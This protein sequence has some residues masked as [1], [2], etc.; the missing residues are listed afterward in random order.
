MNTPLV[1]VVITVRDGESYIG[2]AIE[3]IISQTLDNWRLIIIDDQ[4]T[5][6]TPRLLS[7][8]L[9]IDN[10]IEVHA[11]EGTGIASA[12]QVGLRNAT[13]K[14]VARFDAD[15]ISFPSRLEKQVRHLE[16]H[17]DLVAL[18]SAVTQ[19]D[20]IGKILSTKKMPCDPASIQALLPHRNC[21][22]HPTSIIR[23]S[24]LENIGGY[25]TQFRLA[26]DYDLW[27]RL[28]KEGRIANLPEPLVYYRK[29]STQVTDR[30]RTA[31]LTLYS[32]AA[33]TDYFLRKYDI[34]LQSCNINE[35]SNDDVA[36]KLTLIY[37]SGPEKNDTKAL[38][39][40]GI[41]LLRH[42]NA[43]G[44]SARLKL[45]GAMRPYMSLTERMKFA[46]YKSL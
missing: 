6:G 39:R 10:R 46:I 18:G 14:Y 19:I 11:G 22:Y 37:N 35:L 8:Y 27:L 44:T 24:A 23:R 21:I 45:Q 1:D 4:S 40:H 30:S 2:Q 3:S 17:K 16:L 13:A 36:E 42:A 32:V 15:D 33:A 26:E 5:D 29:H 38:N 25:R 31:Y 9:Q 20:S 12:A 28:I 43:L 34:Q 41:R 7:R